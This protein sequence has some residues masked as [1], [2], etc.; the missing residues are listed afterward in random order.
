MS[1]ILMSRSNILFTALNFD[2][3]EISITPYANIIV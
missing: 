1:T 3:M 2:L